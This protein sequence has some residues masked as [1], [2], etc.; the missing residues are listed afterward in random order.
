MYCSVFVCSEVL[1]TSGGTS[2]AGGSCEAVSDARSSAGE[3]SC[4]F[5][6]RGR[7]KNRKTSKAQ[8]GSAKRFE[9]I[10]HLIKTPGNESQ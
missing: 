5:R 4:A 2:F 1:M 7:I 10:G 3:A 8:R 6:T 9:R